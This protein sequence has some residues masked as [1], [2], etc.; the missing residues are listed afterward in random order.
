[1]SFVSEAPTGA[2]SLL[3]TFAASER[4]CGFREASVFSWWLTS[5]AQKWFLDSY[6]DNVHLLCTALA[7]SND[8]NVFCRE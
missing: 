6:V 5:R 8:D 4:P 1:M 2:E 3:Y 7:T